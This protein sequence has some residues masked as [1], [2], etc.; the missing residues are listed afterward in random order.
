MTANRRS[1]G[2][3]FEHRLLLYLTSLTGEKF[4]YVK[5]IKNGVWFCKTVKNTW[6]LKEFPTREKVENQLSLTNLLFTNGFHRTYRFHPI[7]AKKVCFFENKIYGLIEFIK[8]G[9]SFS[10]QTKN[11]RI[12]AIELLSKF[13]KTTQLFVNEFSTKLSLF[14]Q[15]EKWEARLKE[16]ISNIPQLKKFMPPYYIEVYVEWAKWSLHKLK[17]IKS[18]FDQQ[19]KCVIHGDV[20]HHNFIY[21]FDQQLFLIDFDLIHVGSPVIDYLQF[22]N[23]ILPFIEWSSHE[24]QQMGIIKNLLNR[25]AF[26]IALIYPTDVLR[27]WN[28]FIKTINTKE[29][30]IQSLTYLKEITINQFEQRKS[31][32]NEMINRI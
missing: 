12:Q 2:D 18:Y 7:H 21:N 10:Y 28:R 15:I 29:D 24:L 22:T 5:K 13:H 1:S 32:V 11:N 31:F 3:E 27:E 25:K 30:M 6:V 14:D 17:Q 20:A 8:K 26:V 16:F 9:S 4:L 19:E 23:R